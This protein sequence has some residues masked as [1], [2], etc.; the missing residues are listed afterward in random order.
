MEIVFMKQGLKIHQ[1]QVT[2]LQG[3]LNRIRALTDTVAV[4]RKE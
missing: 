3:Q 1:V 4:R 2:K